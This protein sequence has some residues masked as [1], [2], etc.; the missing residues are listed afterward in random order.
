MRR[1]DLDGIDA[2]PAGAAGGVGERL[3][4]AGKP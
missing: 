2:E 1:V 3:P 4:D